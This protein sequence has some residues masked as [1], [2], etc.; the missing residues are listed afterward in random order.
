MLADPRSR[1]NRHKEAS[2]AKGKREII[3]CEGV[4]AIHVLNKVCPGTYNVTIA[5]APQDTQVSVEISISLSHTIRF[6]EYRVIL[7]FNGV[8]DPPLYAPL[9]VT[10]N[11]KTM[12][13]MIF[14]FPDSLDP[15]TKGEAE[16]EAE[17]KTV[18]L[19]EQASNVEC[20]ATPTTA[21]LLVPPA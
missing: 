19:E 10:L 7:E 6:Q 11:N 13:H 20:Q 14:L 2:E 1:A 12:S 17:A 9:T 16:A 4:D 5:Y 18:G 21:D 8:T 15:S 3:W